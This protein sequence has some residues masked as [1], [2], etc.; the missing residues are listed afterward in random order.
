M[1]Q[2]ERHALI[3]HAIQAWGFLVRWGQRLTFAEFASA[4]R[5]HSS[6]PRAEAVAGVLDGT[7]GFVARDWRGFRANWQ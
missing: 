2:N 5:K 7:T 4:I 6:D 3:R 1:N